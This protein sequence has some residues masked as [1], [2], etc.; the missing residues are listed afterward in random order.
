MGQNVNA[1]HGILDGKEVNLAYLIRKIAEINGLERIRYTTSHPRDMD[2]DLIALH[3]IEE[4]L[5]PFLHL[6]IQS[7]SNKVLKDMNRKYTREF[8]IEI[9]DRLREKCP[10]IVLSSDFIV[11]FPGETDEN[12][13]DTLDLVRKVKYGQC[14]SFKYSMRPGTPAIDREQIPEYIK[15]SRL[16][17]LQE[18]LMK[19]QLHTNQNSVGKVVPVLFDRDGKYADQIIGKTPY[20]QSVYINTATG[21]KTDDLRGQIVN[22]MITNAFA[23]SL[24]GLIVT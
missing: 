20:M 17:A 15:H 22:V 7:G 10:H 23:N 5:M 12:F 24:T 8:Y 6:P 11:G 4:K 16:I 14:Y 2:E 19:Q 3:G 1:Y 9:I 18:E 21:D 13:A